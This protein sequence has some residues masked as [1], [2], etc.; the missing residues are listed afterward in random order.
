MLS[1]SE[2]KGCIFSA[3]K[4]D[5]FTHVLDVCGLMDIDLIGNNFTWVRRAVG[6]PTMMKRLDRA[7]ASLSWRHLFPEAYIEVLGKLHSDHFSLLLRC[8]G[9]QL[10]RGE[11]PF[12]F[13][14]AWTTHPDYDAVVNSAWRQGEQI[15]AD[16]LA[17]VR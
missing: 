4:A 9:Q 14:A 12:R 11:R 1:P 5:I 2:V 7:L 8:D 13:L 3:A 10:V 16:C 17:K 6:T 15:V